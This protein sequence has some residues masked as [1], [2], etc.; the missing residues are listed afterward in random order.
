MPFGAVQ[1]PV[2]SFTEVLVK[3]WAGLD[4]SLFSLNYINPAW[5]SVSSGIFIPAGTYTH[6]VDIR[7]DYQSY[8]KNGGLQTSF[9]IPAQAYTIRETLKDPNGTSYISTRT[10]TDI[11]PW[12]NG[13]GS[14]IG[15]DLSA[16][17]TYNERAVPNGYT[18]LN[19]FNIF[20]CGLQFQGLQPRVV[21]PTVANGFCTLTVQAGSFHAES[22]ADDGFGHGYSCSFECILL[23]EQSVQFTLSPRDILNSNITPGLKVFLVIGPFYDPVGINSRTD[24]PDVDTHTYIVPATTP[25]NQIVDLPARAV[26]QG[27]IVASQRGSDTPSLATMQR[28]VQ[29]VPSKENYNGFIFPPQT[30]LWTRLQQ[31]LGG[32]LG[33][34][35]IYD[36]YGENNVMFRLHADA[37][38]TRVP[39]SG[40]M[41]FIQT[42]PLTLS[43]SNAFGG[44][45]THSGGIWTLKS[46]GGAALFDVTLTDPNT[47][48]NPL[49]SPYRY[50]RFDATSATAI[51]LPLTLYDFHIIDPSAADTKKV[52]TVQLGIGT[53][54]YWVDLM[55]PDSVSVFTGGTWHDVVPLPL[56]E[57]ESLYGF[58][59]SSGRFNGIRHLGDSQVEL[60][61]GT[62]VSFSNFAFDTQDKTTSQIL[63][64]TAAGV[65]LGPLPGALWRIHN[66]GKNA[67]ELFGNP[68]SFGYKNA[69]L[70]PPAVGIQPDTLSM[71]IP[72]QSPLTDRNGFVDPWDINGNVIQERIAIIVDNLGVTYSPGSTMDVS[73]IAT[74][75]AQVPGG[76]AW[77]GSPVAV[78]AVWLWSSL[79]AQTVV[80]DSLSPST[81]RLGDGAPPDFSLAIADTSNTHH[82]YAMGYTT[83]GFGN[84]IPNYP[85]LVQFMTPDHPLTISIWDT[86][87][88]IKNFLWH[89][90]RMSPAS[91][92]GSGLHLTMDRSGYIYAASA[93][94]AG[95]VVQKFNFDGV[96][97]VFTVT[98]VPAK[99]AQ[100]CFL[101]S[102]RLIVVYDD[103]SGNVWRTYSDSRAVH[104]SDPV[105]LWAGNVPAIAVDRGG[106]EYV[107]YWTS[108][109]WWVRVTRDPDFLSFDGAYKIVDGDSTPTR[110]GLEIHPVSDAKL[111]F[112]VEIGGHIRRFVSVSGGKVWE[113][114]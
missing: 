44:T 9:P 112:M 86:N 26:I 85:A 43:A 63:G 45:V 76:S 99:S 69:T 14:T 48:G 41:T 94:S 13:A 29:I 96:D 64:V 87:R 66:D 104:W 70:G 54:T 53:H 65:G 50:L 110:A 51:A 34:G 11:F 7:G 89:H 40:T 42:V 52:Y 88:P 56:I 47:S 101:P 105:N 28:Q 103:A 97:K 8:Y 90:T 62:S 79:F 84:T 68:Q 18:A 78:T 23:P 12:M 67:V 73:A 100:I 21:S 102:G 109:S 3:N 49:A 59:G 25:V 93:T 36:A 39:M 107:A 77:W 19:V 32:P 15:F 10:V 98:T 75:L 5:I 58:P 22:N 82:G 30:T 1:F 83:F 24:Y 55:N 92:P 4:N 81:V 35:T 37:G 31:S 2:L 38:A 71:I 91:P 27:W 57:D 61:G 74:K 111:V 46:S 33:G 16:N 108:N 6:S 80:P 95:V 114:T 72:S 60:F 106:R 113:E 20:V 17:V